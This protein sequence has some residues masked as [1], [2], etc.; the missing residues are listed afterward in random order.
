[1]NRAETGTVTEMVVA[2]AEVEREA[3]ARVVEEREVEMAVVATVGVWG[4][5]RSWQ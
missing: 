1:M 3:V 2:M 4:G 5:R